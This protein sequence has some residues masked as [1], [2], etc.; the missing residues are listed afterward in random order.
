MAQTS[1]T[2]SERS[3]EKFAALFLFNLGGLG[4][5]SEPPT[6]QNRSAGARDWTPPGPPGQAIQDMTRF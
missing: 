1:D 3:A 5:P 6:L 4:P 2:P